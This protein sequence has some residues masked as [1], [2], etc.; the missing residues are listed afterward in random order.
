MKNEVI[1]VLDCSATSN[2]RV[3][4]ADRQGKLSPGPQPPTPASAPRRT[5]AAPVVAGGYSATLRRLLSAPSARELAASDSRHHGDHLQL[6]ARW[7]MSTAHCSTRTI[8]WKCPRTLAVMENI[9]G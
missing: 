6:T 1:L 8:S 3:I 2:V 7:S 5:R 4:A 9:D